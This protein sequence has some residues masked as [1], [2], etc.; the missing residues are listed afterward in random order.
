LV[1]EQGSTAN[2]GDDSSLAVQSKSGQ[3]FRALVRF[4]LPAA[5]AGCTLDRAELRLYADSVKPDRTIQVQAVTSAW[6]EMGV[7]WDTQP[8]TTGPVATTPSGT[9]K[10]WKS[11]D[12][13]QLVGGAE[14]GFLIR[15]ADEN[16]DAEQKFNSREKGT[17]VP[18]LVLTYR[19]Q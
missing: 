9:D 12:V 15:D 10:G 8:A 14:H 1:R 13:T 11:W 3:A 4:A 7:T 17:D 6:E 5:P 2:K 18:T 16:G 19:A